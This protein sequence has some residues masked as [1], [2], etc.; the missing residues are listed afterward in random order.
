MHD[1]DDNRNSKREDGGQNVTRPSS[2]DSNMSVTANTGFSASMGFNPPAAPLPT[3]TDA[4]IARLT[5]IQIK[6]M[7]ELMAYPNVVG[8]GIGFAHE[9]GQ[10]TQTPAIIVMVSEKLPMAQ[11]APDEVLPQEIEGVRIDVQGTGTF[12]AGGM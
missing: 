6:H 7:D 11:L 9:D 12:M 4:Q 8:V 3:L 5:T 10:T 2:S 1:P